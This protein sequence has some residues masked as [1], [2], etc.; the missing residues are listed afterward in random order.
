[1]KIGLTYDLKGDHPTTA[2]AP[3]DSQEEFDSPVTIDG[4]AGV[5]RSLGHEVL[6]LGDG[7][8]F[9]EKVLQ[10][11]PDLVFNFAEGQGIGRCREA[12]VPAALELLNIPYTGSDP[13]T[14][15]STLDKDCAKRIVSSAGVVVPQGLLLHPEDPLEEIEQHPQFPGYPCLLKPAWE[16]SSKGIRSRCL[17]DS[18][19][20]LKDVVATLRRDHHQPILIEEYVTGE[21]L[22]VG[23][24]GN[25]RPHVL[26]IMRVVPLKKEPRFIYSL[27]VKRGWEERVRY[28]CPPLL[29]QAHLEAV[30]KA[31]LQAF[32]VLGCRDVARI[33]FRLRDGIPVFLEVNPLPGLNPETSDLVFMARFMGWSYT[34]LINAILQASLDRLGLTVPSASIPREN[35]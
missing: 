29:P 31:A 33:D 7:R 35:P 14:C 32:R 22:T 11:R 19:R 27:E 20:D 16:G 21:E 13:L 15:A 34:E 1:M 4:I 24:I 6:L 17:V 8:V 9:L 30:E 23:L 5:L 18:S 26:G 28:E 3:D 2:D 10:E 25:D 12:R